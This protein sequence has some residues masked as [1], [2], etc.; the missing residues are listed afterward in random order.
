M[1]SL[2]HCTSP[3]MSGKLAQS[4]S[5]DELSYLVKS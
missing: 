1:S 4:T 3:P 2:K 5:S